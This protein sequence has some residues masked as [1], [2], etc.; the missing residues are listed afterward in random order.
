MRSCL[1]FSR[2]KSSILRQLILGSCIW[3][4]RI[5][6]WYASSSDVV[7]FCW[8]Q[9]QFSRQV[10]TSCF[11]NDDIGFCSSHQSQ[12][13]CEIH[14]AEGPIGSFFLLF[15]VTHCY[16]VKLRLA[17]D[18]SHGAV[19]CHLAFPTRRDYLELFCRFAGTEIEKCLENSRDDYGLLL[20]FPFSG[21]SLLVSRIF[22]TF[23]RCTKQ[24]TLLSS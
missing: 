10:H 15:A 13:F 19:F 18:H 4:T 6:C 16:F 2:V 23:P 8:E 17:N 20:S 3:S 22:A 12:P 24:C 11:M 21:S 9:G 1:W 5:S 14:E 7:S